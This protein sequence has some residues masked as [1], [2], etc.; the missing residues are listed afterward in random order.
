MNLLAVVNQILDQT[1]QTDAGGKRLLGLPSALVKVNL[2]EIAEALANHKAVM[3]S[4]LGRPERWPDRP[5]GRDP[6][7][8]S[9][10]PRGPVKLDFLLTPMPHFCSFVHHSTA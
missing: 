5:R 10:R 9:S 7:A 4:D 8:S 1:G 2:D 3:E 6:L